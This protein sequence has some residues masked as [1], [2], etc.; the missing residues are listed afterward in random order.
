MLGTMSHISEFN[1]AQI[2]IEMTRSRA[3]QSSEAPN[4]SITT[5]IYSLLLLGNRGLSA[6]AK[7]RRPTYMTIILYKFMETQPFP[8]NNIN[9]SNQSLGQTII[10]LYHYFKLA[11]SMS[12][13]PNKQAYV[14]KLPYGLNGI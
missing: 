6:G 9:I 13:F 10:L 7:V 12:R 14:A 8:Y 11:T 1:I 5:H 4:W 2:P 3:K